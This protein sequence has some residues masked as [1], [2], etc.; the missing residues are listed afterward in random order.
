M[1]TILA[2]QH[3][4]GEKEAICPK[5]KSVM[6]WRNMFDSWMGTFGEVEETDSG[7]WECQNKECGY[8]SD[9]EEK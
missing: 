6:T 7:F 2:V 9:E 5:C 1:K 4:T 8:Q 3:A